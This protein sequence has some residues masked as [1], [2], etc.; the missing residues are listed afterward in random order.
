MES[1]RGR[2]LTCEVREARERLREA[3]ERRQ[4]AKESVEA[5]LLSSARVRAAQARLE[6]ARTRKDDLERQVNAAL[7]GLQYEEERARQEEEEEHKRRAMIEERMARVEKL[8]SKVERNAPARKKVRAVA[9]EKAQM[10]LMQERQKVIA[11]LLSLLPLEDREAPTVAEAAP[12]QCV[13]LSGVLLLPKSG[14]YQHMVDAGQDNVLAAA[15]GLLAH[16]TNEIS[17][18]LD[19]HLRHRIEPR[20]SRSVA[21][22]QDSGRE[23]PLYP[24]GRKRLAEF[25]MALRM[26]NSNVCCLCATQGLDV[27]LCQMQAAKNVLRLSRLPNLGWPGV[28]ET[29]HPPSDVDL[30]KG[31]SGNRLSSRLGSRQKSAEVE[32]PVLRLSSPAADSP[33]VDSPTNALPMGNELPASSL[34]FT[35][36]DIR[37]IVEL[38]ARAKATAPQKEEAL[39]WPAGPPAMKG[40]DDD[41]EWVQLG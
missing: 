23:Y 16:L 8:L 35:P 18:Y 24:A 1:E 26:L 30:S 2:A 34:R 25:V 38:Q 11:L 12:E 3:Q 5:A 32:E 17:K 20:G 33:A 7:L 4:S 41:D 14:D 31:K 27:S 15:L 39:H 10:E 37:Y 9:L 6:R 19:V 22:D 36:D 40:D 28:P 13:L 29:L 21:I